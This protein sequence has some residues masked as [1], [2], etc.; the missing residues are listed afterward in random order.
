MDIDINQLFEDRTHHFVAE[1]SDLGLAPG[2]VPN[3]IN[4]SGCGNGQPFFLQYAGEQA[5]MYKQQLGCVGL[6]IYND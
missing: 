1:A 3:V 6:T 2:V 4:V 5:F